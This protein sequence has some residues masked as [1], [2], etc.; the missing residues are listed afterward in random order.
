FFF[1]QAEDGIRDR[2]VTGVQSVLF[3]SFDED[4]LARIVAIAVLDGVDDRLA[5]GDADPMP[6]VLVEA[7]AARQV[8]ADHVNEVE[9]L[10]GAG[11]IGRAS[12]RERGE[13]TM[14]G[15]SWKD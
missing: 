2:N 13:V 1:F 8:V 15:R 12:C 11:K 10:E 6:R 14:G 9:H 7:D 5:D 4:V 3:R